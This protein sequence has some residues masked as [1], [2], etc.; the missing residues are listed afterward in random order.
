[1][2]I[3]DKKTHSILIRVREKSN[4]GICFSIRYVSINAASQCQS[5]S[6]VHRQTISG[7]FT[8]VQHAKI[9]NSP[10]I[11]EL[12]EYSNYVTILAFVQTREFKLVIKVPEE[13]TQIKQFILS[14]D[15]SIYA[16]LSVCASV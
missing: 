1:M 13:D 2:L 6:L 8:Y 3:R 15:N 10:S 14:T 9:S 5:A 4:V 11:G 12:S 7:M 16:S